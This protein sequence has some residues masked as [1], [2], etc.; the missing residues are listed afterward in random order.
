[1]PDAK[2]IALT[3]N[4][5]LG[6][7]GGIV[8]GGY[9]GPAGAEAVNK[10]SGGVDKLLTAYVP[11]ETPKAP[12]PVAKSDKPPPEAPKKETTAMPPDSPI[13]LDKMLAEPDGKKAVEYLETKGWSKDDLEKILARLN[14]APATAPKAPSPP[15]P[16]PA[17]PPAA[18]VRPTPLP[19]APPRLPTGVT[20]QDVEYWLRVL[21]WPEGELDPAL[22]SKY[23]AN[24]RMAIDAASTPGVT[25]EDI[26][27]WLHAYQTPGESAENKAAYRTQIVKGL[28]EMG[29]LQATAE[30]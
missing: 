19:S 13:K 15:E 29:I 26:C 18:P 20:Q 30:K 28:S 3:V 5:I 17:G 16:S 2:E 22:R 8:A 27:Y 10:A 6:G 12:A 14:T 21:R 9:M 24:L 4:Q 7:I 11:G 25:P 1:M 23:M